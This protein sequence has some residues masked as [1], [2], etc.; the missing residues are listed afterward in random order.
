MSLFFMATHFRF[1]FAQ[2]HLDGKQHLIFF[3]KDIAD[4]NVN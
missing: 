2:K 4:N 3:T 1:N